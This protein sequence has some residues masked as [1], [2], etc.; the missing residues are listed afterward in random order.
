MVAPMATILALSSMCAPKSTSAIRS[1]PSG[2][3]RADG[4]GQVRAGR[5]EYVRRAQGTRSILLTRAH[6]GETV[7]PPRTAI[8]VAIAP[9]PPT[10][11]WT[12]TVSPVTGPSAKTAR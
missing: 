8:W 9:T 5:V 2:A 3:M 1:T 10:A 6:D 11:P 7:A 4:L 12:S